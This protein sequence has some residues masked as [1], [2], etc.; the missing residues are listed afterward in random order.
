MGEEYF[1]CIRLL[2]RKQSERR[3]KSLETIS[4]RA[5]HS[6]RNLSIRGL[7][8]DLPSH[9]T[10]REFPVQKERYAVVLYCA[11]TLTFLTR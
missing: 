10:T 7:C 3:G 8:R 1:G 9:L 11:N 5:V 2:F 6:D 4:A